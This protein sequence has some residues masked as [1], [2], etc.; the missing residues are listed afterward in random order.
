MYREKRDLKTMIHNMY[1][2]GLES[3]SSHH[4]FHTTHMVHVSRTANPKRIFGDAKLCFYQM[5]QVFTYR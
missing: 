5:L 3:K 2:V 1:I 4:E